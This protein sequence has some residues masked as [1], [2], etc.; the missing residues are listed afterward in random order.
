QEGYDL[1][2]QKSRHSDLPPAGYAESIVQI[3]LFNE[4]FNRGHR[5]YIHEYQAFWKE[6]CYKLL[7]RKQQQYDMRKDSPRSP[8]SRHDKDKNDR[9]NRSDGKASLAFIEQ[10]FDKAVTKILALRLQRQ[11]QVQ[12]PRRNFQPLDMGLERQ[13]ANPDSRTQILHVNIF[14]MAKDKQFLLPCECD[15]QRNPDTNARKGT[16]NIH[17]IYLVTPYSRDVIQYRVLGRLAHSILSLYRTRESVGVTNCQCNRA[18]VET[19]SCRTGRQKFKSGGKSNLTLKLAERDKREQ[20]LDK[21]IQLTKRI[22]DYAARTDEQNQIYYHNNTNEEQ[23]I[24]SE[25]EVSALEAQNKHRRDNL[26]KENEVRTLEKE[27]IELT[28]TL[29]KDQIDSNPTLQVDR[30]NPQSPRL[31]NYIEQTIALEVEERLPLPNYVNNMQDAMLI[32]MII[33]P[34]R[35]NFK[36]DSSSKINFTYPPPELANNNQPQFFEQQIINNRNRIQQSLQLLTQPKSP[37]IQY[38]IRQVDPQ[39]EVDLNKQIRQLQKERDMMQLRFEQEVHD[40]IFGNLDCPSD[41]NNS[42]MDKQ[43]QR[44][45]SEEAKDPQSI[46]DETGKH[47]KMDKQHENKKSVNAEVSLTKEKLPKKKRIRHK[48]GKKT[49]VLQPRKENNLNNED[50]TRNLRSGT[51]LF[52]QKPEVKKERK[53]TPNKS[54]VL[55]DNHTPHPTQPKGELLTPKSIR[56]GLNV[57]S[58]MSN[59]PALRLKQFSLGSISSQLPLLWIRMERGNTMENHQVRN[60]RLST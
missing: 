14:E 57:D 45:N 52:L 58:G 20:A 33:S 55:Q 51:K 6:Y 37:Q 3:R 42:E 53:K 44:Q 8:G 5:F 56:V 23:M 1:V 27:R 46:Q 30:T 48:R 59:H 26:D 15:Q 10:Q 7:E 19:Q 4:A 2:D 16:P 50:Q 29:M 17:T 38:Q 60:F 39:K 32:N 28:K 25:K 47:I 31:P 22:S 49:K 40:T 36:Q 11:T 21:A 13:L 43:S 34:L 12:N 54:K 24:Q 41:L 18:P 9:N 35:I